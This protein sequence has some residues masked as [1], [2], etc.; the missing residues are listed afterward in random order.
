MPESE[1][2]TNLSIHLEKK[3]KNLSPFSARPGSSCMA[4]LLT[5]SRVFLSYGL[6]AHASLHCLPPNP[7]VFR[8]HCLRSYSQHSV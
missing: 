6:L 7:L 3:K 2:L 4:Q 8:P 1:N 5:P